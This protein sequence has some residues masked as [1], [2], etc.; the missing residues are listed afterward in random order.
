[1]V[2]KGGFKL[3]DNRAINVLRNKLIKKVYLITPNIPEAEILTKAKIKNLEDMKFAA[4]ILLNYGVKK[5][6]NK[7]WPYKNQNF[8][9]CIFKQKRNQ[10]FF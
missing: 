6:F 2:A 10:N 8:T 7:R 5:C 4:N 9:R 1:M 3:I